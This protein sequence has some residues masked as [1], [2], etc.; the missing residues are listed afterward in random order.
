[1]KAIVIGLGSSGHAA[2]RRVAR[3]GRRIEELARGQVVADRLPGQGYER[4]FTGAHDHSVSKERRT[5]K[6]RKSVDA[7]AEMA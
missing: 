4:V 3:L 5:V 6:G 7:R 2:R 1:M